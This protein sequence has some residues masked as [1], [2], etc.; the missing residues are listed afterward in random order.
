METEP[1]LVRRRLEG[2]L[3]G[4]AAGL[5]R[6][7]ASDGYP[8][9]GVSRPEAWLTPARMTDAWVAV[10]SGA[11]VGHVAVTRPG[12][13]RAAAL[14]VGH[15]GQDAAG[16]AVLARLFVVPEARNLAAGEGLVGAAAAR[17]REQG[18]RLVL[19]VLAKDT[20]A[21][22]LYTRLTRVVASG[23]FP[24]GESELTL[25]PDRLDERLR[26]LRPAFFDRS[27]DRLGGTGEHVV[28]LRPTFAAETTRSRQ[29]DGVL[30]VYSRQ[31]GRAD[32]VR[33]HTRPLSRVEGGPQE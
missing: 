13:E 2:D 4:A 26:S 32:W 19:D 30:E 3:A 8:V 33:V 15:S 1:I 10:R 5:V 17:A 31:A 18:I 28:V 7:H 27:G 6:V 23:A 14:W 12:G 9:E 21:I 29:P 20:A 22:R 16:V 25:S 24:D 11:V